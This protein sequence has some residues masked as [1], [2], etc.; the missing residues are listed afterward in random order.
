MPGGGDESAVEEISEEMMLE[1]S[2]QSSV[3]DIELLVLRGLGLTNV[4]R[5]CMTPS[6][7]SL[8]LSHNAVRVI[9]LPP[10]SLPFLEEIN[11]NNNGMSTLNWVAACPSIQRIY[12]SSNEISSASP[13]AGCT[14]LQGAFL[15]GNRIS[16]LS[17]ALAVLEK[18]AS[19]SELELDGNPCD[20]GNGYRPA[21]ITRWE[22]R[23]HLWLCLA[24]ILAYSYDRHAC[25]PGQ[26]LAAAAI[27]RRDHHIN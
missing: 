10:N 11:V 14:K 24:M 18:I 16:D 7:K 6:L 9:D 19:L 13:L 15:H 27:G 21:V 4:A 20:V 5:L 1:F 17:A 26:A 23:A 8:S 2:G 22:A 3:Q 12:A 25:D